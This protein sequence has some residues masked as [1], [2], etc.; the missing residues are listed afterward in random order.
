MLCRPLLLSQ[1]DT[2][3]QCTM[4]ETACI[5]RHHQ[6]NDSLLSCANLTAISDVRNY[7]RCAA[8]AIR[9][10]SWSSRTI[11]KKWGKLNHLIICWHLFQEERRLI[12]LTKLPYFIYYGSCFSVELNSS[13]V[14]VDLIPLF[15]WTNLVLGGQ[16][17]GHVEADI[18]TKNVSVP[19]AYLPI[20]RF[21]AIYILSH[22]LGSTGLLLQLTD[23]FRKFTRRPW[24]LDS[25]GRHTHLNACVV[26][27]LKD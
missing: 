1:L 10:E 19:I 25:K 18:N 3:P 23:S 13:V 16:L 12:Q 8:L 14:I 24:V 4:K 15:R 7:L 5:C 20:I 11:A 6:V 22:G 17:G 26:L 2:I 9:F 21:T 27:D